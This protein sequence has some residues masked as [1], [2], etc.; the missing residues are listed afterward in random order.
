MRDRDYLFCRRSEE[1]EGGLRY[2]VAES[3][4]DH[5]IRPPTAGAIRVERYRSLATCK[6]T[7]DGRTAFVFVSH[8]DPKVM[9]LPAAFWSWIVAR[10]IPQ[11]W[12][13]LSQACCRYQGWC[14]SGR[15]RAGGPATEPA[16]AG[17]AFDDDPADVMVKV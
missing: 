9:W 2:A 1:L 5:A 11:F 10:T 7:P 15:P 16:V 14:A 12:T 17:L 4:A 3:V 6:D 8:E 13:T